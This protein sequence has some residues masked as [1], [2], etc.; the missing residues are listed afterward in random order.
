[1]RKRNFFSKIAVQGMKYFF[2]FIST[3]FGSYA[4]SQIKWT[5]RWL[6]FGDKNDKI[7]YIFSKQV[8]LKSPWPRITRFP[9]ITC[10]FKINWN[11]RFKCYDSKS[12]ESGRPRLMWKLSNSGRLC[13][14]SLV[15]KGSVTHHFGAIK[16]TVR[17]QMKWKVISRSSRLSSLSFR[18]PDGI[19]SWTFRGRIPPLWVIAMWVN[20]PNVSRRRHLFGEWSKWGINGT[21]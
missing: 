19:S 10:L 3:N 9:I 6:V 5:G 7:K 2:K 15:F 12:K 13:D 18:P 11:K 16:Q 1:M 14:F 4:C 20:C 21:H 8:W 17:G